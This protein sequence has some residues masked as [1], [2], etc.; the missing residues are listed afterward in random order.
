MKVNELISWDGDNE[1]A[2]A[3]GAAAGPDSLRFRF[4]LG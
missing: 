4:T 3:A 2:M 1:A